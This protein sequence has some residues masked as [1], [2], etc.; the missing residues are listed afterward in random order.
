[1]KR[2]FSTFLF[3]ALCMAVSF[4]EATAVP[5][6]DT[7]TEMSFVREMNTCAKK[8]GIPV[9]IKKSKSSPTKKA[10][11]FFY[12]VYSPVNIQSEL[13][14]AIIAK[15][16][17]KDG[18]IYV[19]V[20]FVDSKDRL[21]ELVSQMMAVERTMGMP[22]GEAHLD[23]M[24]AITDALTKGTGTYWSETTNRKYVIKFIGSQTTPSLGLTITAE[25]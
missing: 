8:E 12:S 4:C 15:S 20:V 9:Q 23:G 17:E 25:I 24:F 13:Q 1:M 3:L 10:G 2:I 5:L 22:G 11:A 21:R 18:P 16:K 7:I 6:N 19:I 14:N